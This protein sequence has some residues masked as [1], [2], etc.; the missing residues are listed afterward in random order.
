[1]IVVG[2]SRSLWNHRHDTR[3]GTVSTH[4][5]GTA[6]NSLRRVVQTSW[7][8]L[9]RDS[10][11]RCRAATNNKYSDVVVRLLYQRDSL[12]SY[13]LGGIPISFLM[14]ASHGTSTRMYVNMDSPYLKVA[15]FGG[16]ECGCKSTIIQQYSNTK[17][18]QWGLS[19]TN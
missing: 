2:Q 12:V 8:C 18:P 15:T 13:R 7:A 17:R 11:A 5:S 14:R 16:R 3:D 4:T 9:E 1:M 10:A 19:E 6:A